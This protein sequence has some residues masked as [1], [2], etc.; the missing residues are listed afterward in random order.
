M[1]MSEQ[2]WSKGIKRVIKCWTMESKF[3]KEWNEYMKEIR[4]YFLKCISDCSEDVESLEYTRMK[5]KVVGWS[6]EK[7]R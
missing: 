7:N 4:F 2:E 1:R 3:G 6:S 5:Y